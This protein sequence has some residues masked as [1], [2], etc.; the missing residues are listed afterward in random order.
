MSITDYGKA[1]LEVVE[2]SNNKKHRRT[3]EPR[4]LDVVPCRKKP[5]LNDLGILP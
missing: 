4:R 1:K 3:Y 5:K 2:K